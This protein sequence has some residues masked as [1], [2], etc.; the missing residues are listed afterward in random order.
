MT[1]AEMID[2]PGEFKQIHHAEERT[3]FAYDD[4]QVRSNEIRPLLWNR[5]NRPI[6]GP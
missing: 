3:T 5:A 4:L 2:K 1:T 6:F